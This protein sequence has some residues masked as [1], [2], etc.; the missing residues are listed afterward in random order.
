VPVE[1]W[2]GSCGNQVWIKAAIAADRDFVRLCLAAPRVFSRTIVEKLARS[3]E[4]IMDL[5]HLHLM[6]NHVP[7][8]GVVFG[9]LIGFVGVLARSKTA[10]RVGLGMIV[11]SA[12]IAIPVYLTG[13]T[14]EELVE[15]L[16]GVS[17]AVI[18]QHE[19]AATLSLALA[20]VAGGL[21]L[22]TLFFGRSL[23]SKIPGYLIGATLLVALVAT[24]SMARTANL[25]G[26]IRHTEIRGTGNTGQAV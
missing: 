26:Q 10:T 4:V 20:C 8:T 12:L 15:G 18:S 5:T 22:L 17:E 6:L 14:A 19:S 13:D 3:L 1:Q 11:F 21:A 2:N 25:G 23:V 9:F 16:P 7:V 24:A